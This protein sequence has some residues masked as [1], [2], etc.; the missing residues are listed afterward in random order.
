MQTIGSTTSC[1]KHVAS[2]KTWSEAVSLCAAEGASIPLPQNSSDDA[3]YYAYV[4]SLGTNNSWLDGEDASS[5]GTW[6][7]SSGASIG[8]FNWRS[9]QPDNAGGNENMLHYH[10]SWG[11]YWNDITPTYECDVMCQKPPTRK[12]SYPENTLVVST[13]DSAIAGLALKKIT[14]NINLNAPSAIGVLNAIFPF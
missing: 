2:S 9:G 12:R 5:E 10:P 7:T 6:R 11:G 3:Q 8:F 13:A 4:V 14:F 1:F